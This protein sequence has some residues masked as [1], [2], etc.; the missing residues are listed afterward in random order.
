MLALQQQEPCLRR[1]T[2]P[3]SPKRAQGHKSAPTPTGTWLLGLGWGCL[4]ARPAFLGWNGKREPRAGGTCTGLGPYQS[5]VPAIVHRGWWRGLLGAALA[6][7]SRHHPRPPHCRCLAD[8]LL[9]RASGRRAHPSC[10]SSSCQPRR[11]RMSSCRYLGTGGPWQGR[12]PEKAS[13][14]LWSGVL[15]VVPT[16]VLVAQALRGSGTDRGSLS[17]QNQVC[18]GPQSHLASPQPLPS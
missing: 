12:L 7:P 8:P 1:S 6:R 10:P 4:L 13:Q 15:G 5:V 14:K 17:F 2:W 9:F 3:R 11:P 16:T 18:E